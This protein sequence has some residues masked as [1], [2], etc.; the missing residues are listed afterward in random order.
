MSYQT[1]LASLGAGI[2]L[3]NSLPHLISG[4]RGDKFPTPFAKPSGIG[5]SSPLCNFLWGAFNLI[6]G[7]DLWSVAQF[8]IGLNSETFVFFVGFIFMGIFS[9][10]HFG[11]V[12]NKKPL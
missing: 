3:C 9:S 7:C 11:R 6:I 4:L 10:L 8:M 12:R 5:N 1:I 2:F